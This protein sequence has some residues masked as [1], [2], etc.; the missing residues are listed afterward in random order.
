MQYS[1]IE[2]VAKFLQFVSEAEI[3][4]SGR[5]MSPQELEEFRYQDGSP[6]DPAVSGWTFCG[7]VNPKMLDLIAAGEKI[8]HS[9]TIW[10][11]PEGTYVLAL[12]Q[13]V[14]NWAHRFIVPLSG[15]SIRQCV[16][17]VGC[18][19]II[20]SL[21]TRFGD[22]A[23]VLAI[24]FSP[25]LVEAHEYIV[26]LEK[27]SVFALADDIVSAS[28][29]FLRPDAMCGDGQS[30]KAVCVSAVAAPEVR[31]FLEAHQPSVSSMMQ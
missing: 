29:H 9:A 3:L 15:Q 22:L 5:L 10:K 26:D 21:S 1:S 28:L 19:P 11:A 23:R 16:S 4:A 24:P 2:V 6:I 25:E 18:I 14:E 8:R 20:I 12:Q 7:D 17:D 30:I 13:Q 27:V 31:A